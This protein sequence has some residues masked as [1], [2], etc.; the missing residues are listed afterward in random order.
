MLDLDHETLEDVVTKNG[1]EVESY[2]VTTPD[3]YILK[4]FRI[5]SPQVKAS[6]VKAPVV[7]M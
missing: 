5:R 1:F 6:G 4:V 2:D 7:F 3:G